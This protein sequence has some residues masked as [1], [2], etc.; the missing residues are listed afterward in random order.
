MFSLCDVHVRVCTSQH[1]SFEV[2]FTE[3]VLKE[4][5]PKCFPR[6]AVGF[7]FALFAATDIPS[8]RNHTCLS[9]R[10]LVMLAFHTLASWLSGEKRA[11]VCGDIVHSVV[12][13]KLCR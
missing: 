1:F 3:V 2:F 13:G 11:A 10:S 12:L 8:L 6:T 9:V 4:E 5:V 7:L